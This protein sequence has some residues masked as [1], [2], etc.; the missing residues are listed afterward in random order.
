[1]PRQVFL[2]ERGLMKLSCA[3]PNGQ[4]TILSLRLP[5]QLIGDAY[6]HWLGE[7][8]PVSAI[9]AIDCRV[10]CISIEAIQA[11]LQRNPEVAQFLICQQGLDLY[12]QSAALIEAKTL[13]APER[14]GQFVQHL[15]IVFDSN[16]ARGPVRLPLPLS[17]AEIASLLGITKEYFSRLKKQMQKKGHFQRKGRTLVIS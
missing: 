8:Y 14:F 1:M 6:I 3:L 12:N 4:Q 13:N 9:A 10:C 15:T 5:G 16:R 7:S 17:D 2:L 11:E